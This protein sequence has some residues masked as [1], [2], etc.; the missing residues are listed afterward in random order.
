MKSCAVPLYPAWAMTHP[1]VQHL[2]AIDSP[3][4]LVTQYPSQLA[5]QLSW[6]SS[7]CV[8]VTLMLFNNGPNVE[9]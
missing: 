8:Q 9:G 3:H 1:F 7:A 4:P 2:H 6:Y 5:D